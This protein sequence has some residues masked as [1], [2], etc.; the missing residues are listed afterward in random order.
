M[1][2]NPQLGEIAA[3]YG[4]SVAQLCVRWC[5][6]NGVL[7]LPKSVHEERII[8]N[9]QVFDF[10]I[11]AGDMETINALPYIGGSGNHPDKVDF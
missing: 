10:A 7:P 8:E 2:T 6:Q 5:L 11:S 9:A 4:K 3:K 1:L